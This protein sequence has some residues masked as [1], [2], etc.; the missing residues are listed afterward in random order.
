[1]NATAQL[2]RKIVDILTE[3]RQ[4]L[5][6]LN[7]INQDELNDFVRRYIDTV[8]NPN[9]KQWFKTNARI[10]LLK[11]AGFLPP[12]S[13]AH[14]RPEEP[15]TWNH[16]IPPEELDPEKIPDWAK[17]A[18]KNREPVYMFKPTEKLHD[19]MTKI[20]TFMDSP[21][22]QQ[23]KMTGI[24]FPDMLKMAETFI[25]TE[26]NKARRA[27]KQEAT[28]GASF[29]S[30]GIRKVA[31]MDKGYYWVQLIATPEEIANP[32]ARKSV[33][34]VE[35][36]VSKSGTPADKYE[37][38]FRSLRDESYYM[39]NGKGP[40]KMCIGGHHGYNHYDHYIMGRTNGAHYSLRDSQN[41]PWVT[42]TVDDNEISQIYGR[43]NSQV[44]GRYIPYIRK[45]VLDQKFGVRY[46]SES[47]GLV[48]DEQ[49]QAHPVEAIP[50]GTTVRGGV[51]MSGWDDIKLPDHLTVKGDLNIENTKITELPPALTVI[52][53]L[54][55]KGTQVTS[56]P[57]DL[58][59]KFISWGPPL[60]IEEVKKFAYRMAIPRM[61][62]QFDADCAEQKLSKKKK[63]AEW[64]LV[65]KEVFDHFMNDPEVQEEI[66][67]E[68]GQ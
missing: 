32:N 45:F 13:P 67:A 61:R 36:N 55:I 57:E 2:A 9:G 68:M 56:L 59:A 11:V 8:Q 60:P 17:E 50:P 4:Y 37:S 33:D 47:L 29:E 23:K 5:I 48:N 6:E 64:P 44:E 18:V 35:N 66:I 26:I 38:R 51:N 30:M 62:A 25:R 53:R 3:G 39:S 1:V 14:A 41:R 65:L 49:G 34:D 10:Y 27:G 20:V 52:G 19:E 43:E 63:E 40:G 31:Q 15:D 16:P 24:G 28:P 21:I 7:V 22:G 46:G 12:G 54:N 42:F 58:N